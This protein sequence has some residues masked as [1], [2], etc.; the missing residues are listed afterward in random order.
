MIERPY[1]PEYFEILRNIRLKPVD[2]EIDNR[3]AEFSRLFWEA[4]EVSLKI[5][6]Y[7]KFVFIYFL[8]KYDSGYECVY[9]LT[10]LPQMPPSSPK[11]L[12]ELPPASIPPN[13]RF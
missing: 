10:S 7:F 9:S 4:V 5:I 11:Q 13:L 8:S 1:T 6:F 12:P 3:E 2:E